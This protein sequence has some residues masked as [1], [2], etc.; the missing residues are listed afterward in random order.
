MIVLGVDP[1]T[2]ATGYGVVDRQGSRY[3]CLAEGDVRAPARWSME[4]RLKTIHDAM[5]EL[6]QRH[7][8]EAVAVEDAF[9][10]KLK[11]P[12]TAIKLGQARGVILLA[13]AQ[14]G[15][16][17]SNYS[18]NVVKQ[19]VVGNGRAEKQQVAYMV[20]R[21]LNLSAPP[22]SEHAADA[23]G[24]ALCLLQRGAIDAMTNHTNRAKTVAMTAG[25]NT[26]SNRRRR[27]P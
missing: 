1:G 24:L 25:A 20:T 17:V 12:Q 2:V 26:P 21:L 11:S 9:I 6:I 13:A 16:P 3:V 15:L 10:S 8:P 23:L 18:P 7:R 5:I 14:A 19:S 22:K 4:L 27:R